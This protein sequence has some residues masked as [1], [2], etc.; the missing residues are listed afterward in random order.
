MLLR[1]E[2]YAGR[3]PSAALS[4]GHHMQRLAAVHSITTAPPWGQR[5]TKLATAAL[6]PPLRQ[7]HT[8]TL[9]RITPKFG[10]NAIG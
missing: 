5:L 9:I 7:C 6:S 10:Q 8:A 4:D 1:N 2:T 3:R